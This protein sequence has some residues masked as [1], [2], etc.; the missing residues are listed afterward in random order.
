MAQQLRRENPA[1]RLG[2]IFYIAVLMDQQIVRQ[3]RYQRTDHC[4]EKRTNRLLNYYFDIDQ[5][6]RTSAG[7]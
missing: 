2:S 4:K 3:W 7:A 6:V 5:C 1:L